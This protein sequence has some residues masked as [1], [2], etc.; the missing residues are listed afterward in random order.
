MANRELLEKMK[1]VHAE[2]HGVYGSPRM[3]RELKAQ[4]VAC[5]ENC[6]ARLMRK[7]DL[8][9]QQLKAYK[10]TTRADATHP[11][12]PNLLDGD[13]TAERPDE[14]WL[15]DISYIRTQEGWLYLA[16][17]M[18]LFSRRIV[19]WAMASRMTSSLVE[20]A[21]R[22]AIR[23]RRPA[24]G[25]IYHSDRGSQYTGSDYQ[26]LLTS[27]LMLASMSSTGNCYDNAP[28][29]SFLGTLKTEWVHHRRYRTREEA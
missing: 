24:A 16:A 14:I 19:G 9:G 29:E 26:E 27:N 25:A 22:M 1:A 23:Q 28:T 20:S 12:A 8:Q 15:S 18:D 6:V 17:I 7:H 11:V 2:N 10:V 4:G 21:L 3:Y 13:F 5:S